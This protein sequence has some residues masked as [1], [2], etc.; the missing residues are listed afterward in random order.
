MGSSFSQNQTERRA[1]LRIAEATSWKTI[2]QEIRQSHK[3]LKISKTNIAMSCKTIILRGPPFDSRS[4]SFTTPWDFWSETDNLWAPP[5]QIIIFRIKP[6]SLRKGE[7]ILFQEKSSILTFDFFSAKFRFFVGKSNNFEV[8]LKW[9]VIRNFYVYYKN[10]CV[11][12]ILTFNWMTVEKSVFPHFNFFSSTILC[13]S[14]F[15]IASREWLTSHCIFH[16]SMLR[17]SHTVVVKV[18]PRLIIVCS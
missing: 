14:R 18:G 6:D 12:Y 3:K 16:L 1:T 15:P 8:A 10:R 11:Q 17:R 5:K 9:R 7:K 2:P 13:R 4:S